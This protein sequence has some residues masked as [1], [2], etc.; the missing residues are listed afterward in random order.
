MTE[1]PERK[2]VFTAKPPNPSR[3]ADGV[4]DAIAAALFDGR[5]SP[6]EPL[7]PEGEIAREFGVSK[8]IAREALRQLTA[9]GL[10]FTQQGKVAR[11]KALS[12][13]SMDK[14]ANRILPIVDSNKSAAIRNARTM[15]TGAENGGRLDS[16]HRL[17]EDGVILEKGWMAT[18]DDRVR[19]SHAELDGEYVGIDDPFSNGLMYPGDPDGDPEEVYNCRCTMVT[20]IVAFKGRRI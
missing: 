9:A 12:G 14:I 11:A 6:G 1:I 8:P 17:E 20:R 5:I 4:S 19:E 16:Y 7:P 13:E 18:M 15:V 2:P 3:L 10:I